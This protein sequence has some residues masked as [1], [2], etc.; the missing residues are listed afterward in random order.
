M[1]KKGFSSLP[2]AINARYGSMACIT[3]FLAI[4]YRLEQE[5]WSNALVVASFYGV[6]GSWSWWT[7]ASVCTVIPCVYV[8][9]GG[10]RSSLL[11]DMMQGIVKSL[12]LIGTLIAIGVAVKK[13]DCGERTDCNVF[14]WNPVQKRNPFSLEGGQDLALVGL[15]QGC[16][17]YGFFDPVLTDRAFMIEP[18]MM[19]KVGKN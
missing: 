1:R 15:L 19:V 11:T 7:A 8:F 16:L 9:I 18:K 2:E 3:F 13:L 17:S 14:L 6:E 10:L 5:V 12:F 4:L